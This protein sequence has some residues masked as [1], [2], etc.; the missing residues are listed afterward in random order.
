MGGELL[1]WSVLDANKTRDQH[2]ATS[3]MYVV[4]AF[5]NTFL[6]KVIYFQSAGDTFGQ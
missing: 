4:L 5:V 6:A 3:Y 1:S 2:F